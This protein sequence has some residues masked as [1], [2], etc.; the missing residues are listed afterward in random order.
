MKSHLMIGLVVIV[1]LTTVT[2][3]AQGKHLLYYGKC[4]L[5]KLSH[6]SIMS[7]C[8]Y[9]VKLFCLFCLVK[10]ILWEKMNSI[11]GDGKLILLI[12]WY[13][14]TCFLPLSENGKQSISKELKKYIQNIRHRRKMVWTYTYEDYLFILL[15]LEGSINM[16]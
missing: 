16:S 2:N 13:L 6:A 14:H 3:F 9:G 4:K 1:L 10:F 12:K 5:Q 8:Y 11:T 7:F 15:V